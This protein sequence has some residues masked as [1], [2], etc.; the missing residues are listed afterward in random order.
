MRYST[1][2]DEGYQ[3]GGTPGGK[4]GCGLAALVGGPLLGFVILLS[5]QET[6]FQTLAAIKISNGLL[7]AAAL[8]IA[9]AV[10]FGSRV[11]INSIIRRRT[12]GR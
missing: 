1:V 10:G 2:M 4:W 11:L 6:A 7:M 9:A 5:A 12:D 8:A 3:G